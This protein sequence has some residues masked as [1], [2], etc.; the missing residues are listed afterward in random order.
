M[1]KKETTYL[2]TGRQ[3]IADVKQLNEIRGRLQAIVESDKL[4][5][6]Y[7]QDI[8]AAGNCITRVIILMSDMIGCCVTEEVIA[9][10]EVAL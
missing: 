3:L 9:G 10:N 5:A 1:E 6:C 7:E 8:D 4:G 2:E